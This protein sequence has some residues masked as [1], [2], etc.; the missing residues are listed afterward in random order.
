M[1][2]ESQVELSERTPADVAMKLLEVS[3]DLD[4]AVTVCETKEDPPVG[5]FMVEWSGG[6][7]EYLRDHRDPA[8]RDRPAQ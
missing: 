7:A 8:A 3:A 2:D 1:S 4:F 6:R 5:G